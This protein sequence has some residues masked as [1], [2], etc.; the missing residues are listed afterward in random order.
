MTTISS[1]RL[2][3]NHIFHL[4]R[5]SVQDIRISLILRLVAIVG[6]EHKWIVLD[7]QFYFAE[8]CGKRFCSE[9]FCATIQSTAI[10]ANSLVG[11][12][13]Y[14]KHIL[15]CNYTLPMHE[16]LVLKLFCTTN[17]PTHQSDLSLTSALQWTQNIKAINDTDS[18][19]LW[20][21]NMKTN[22]WLKW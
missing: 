7:S 16:L 4:H 9:S 11:F 13:K 6:S 5:V 19:L 20:N 14:R 21:K 17:P 3:H 18:I 2:M 8:T 1:N 10:C 15:A 12:Q 22:I